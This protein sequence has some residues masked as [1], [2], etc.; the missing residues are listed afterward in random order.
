MIVEITTFYLEMLDPAWLAPRPLARDDVEI[1]RCEV[2][3]P[4]LNRFLYTTVGGDWYWIDRLAWDRKRW[5]EWVDRPELQTWL[6]SVRGTPAGYYE[7]EAQPGG[8]VEIVYFGL[9]PAFA[10]HGIGGGLLT[11]AVET[12]WRSGASRLWVHT[13]TL[14]HPVALA[15]YKARGFRVYREEIGPVELPDESPGPWPGAR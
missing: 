6:V 14:D 11:H 3:L 1:R 13:C 8:D 10:G 15:N 2:P 4:E 7:L 5:L 9:A 12:A